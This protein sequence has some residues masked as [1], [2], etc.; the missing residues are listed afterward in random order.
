MPHTATEDHTRIFRKQRSSC[1][2]P[3][4]TGN[5]SNL[6]WDILDV[7]PTILFEYIGRRYLIMMV[8][9]VLVSSEH[10]PLPWNTHVLYID[11]EKNMNK[12]FGRLE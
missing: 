6:R 11:G 8:V 1:A 2:P 4:L 5:S 9:S 3:S 10:V 12:A 7:Q